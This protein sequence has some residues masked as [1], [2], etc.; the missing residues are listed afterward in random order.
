MGRAI[1]FREDFEGS[2][3]RLRIPSDPDHCFRMIATTD[4]D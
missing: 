4:S 2:A 1:G 3:L